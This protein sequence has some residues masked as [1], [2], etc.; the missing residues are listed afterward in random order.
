MSAEKIQTRNCPFC[1][2][3]IK[4]DATRCK[5][6]R[7]AIVPERPAHGGECPFCKEAIDSEA[8]KCRFCG[9]WVGGIAYDDG[10]GCGDGGDSAAVARRGSVTV[11]P[12]RGLEPSCE[13]KWMACK[14]SCTVK[15]GG[16]GMGGRDDPAM[17]RA[18]E[19][20]CDASYR[21]CSGSISIY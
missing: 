9:S 5:Y 16:L 14:V 2:E 15:Y 4:A 12:G 20:A 6:C 13:T 21:M 19:D 10:C 8:L 18:C 17:L 1:K 11:G 3:E 7:S